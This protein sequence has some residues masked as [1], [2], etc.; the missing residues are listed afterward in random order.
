[1]LE[2][3]NILFAIMKQSYYTSLKYRRISVKHF[4]GN[5]CRFEKQATFNGDILCDYLIT[6]IHLKTLRPL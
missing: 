1:M 5:K 4:R 6:F 3:Y 2:R